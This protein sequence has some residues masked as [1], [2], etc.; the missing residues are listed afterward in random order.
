MYRGQH[1]TTIFNADIPNFTNCS[2]SDS[3]LLFLPDNSVI[4]TVFH[5]E[6]ENGIFDSG[7]NA[8][9]YFPINADV[10]GTLYTNSQGTVFSTLDEATSFEISIDE[11]QWSLTTPSL[12]TVDESGWSGVAMMYYFGITPTNNLITD[13]EVS[14]DGINDACNMNSNAYAICFNEGNYYP[15]G[16]M[17]VHLDPLYT[18]VSTN[19]EPISISGNDLTFEV[20]PLFFQ[21]DFFAVIEIQNPDEAAFGQSVINTVE[22]Y[23]TVSEG[24]LSEMIDND[25]LNLIVT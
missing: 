1:D 16:E 18:V 13:V 23:Y 17:V 24:V 15:G 12:V 6:N 25:S 3:L 10:L 11:S 9:P 22:G 8:I 19:P 20:P 14:L 4:L 21:E 2:T 7:E 5:D